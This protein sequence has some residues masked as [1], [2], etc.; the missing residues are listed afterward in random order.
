MW[1]NSTSVFQNDEKNFPL[2]Y[3]SIQR[4]VCIGPHVD[5]ILE[6]FS[7]SNEFQNEARPILIKSCLTNFKS[8]VAVKIRRYMPELHL[9]QSE[10]FI[11]VETFY[12]FGCSWMVHHLSFDFPSFL[13]YIQEC[14]Q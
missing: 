4:K 1:Y 14:K 12:N 11:L 2:V 8:C 10:A 9:H 3:A 7:K 6:D 5:K 13:C